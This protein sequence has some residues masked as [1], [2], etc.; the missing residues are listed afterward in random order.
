MD[1]IPDHCLSFY[2]DMFTCRQTGDLWIS[3]TLIPCFVQEKHDCFLLQ[4][5]HYN[6]E[7]LQCLFLLIGTQFCQLLNSSCWFLTRKVP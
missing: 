2:I 5:K 1:L 6:P 4:E 7:H 3:I